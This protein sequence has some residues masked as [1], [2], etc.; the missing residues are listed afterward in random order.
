[1]D[2]QVSC[3]NELLRHFRWKKAACMDEM[4]R[5][6]KGNRFGQASIFLFRVMMGKTKSAGEI[7]SLLGEYESLARRQY[8]ALQ[9]SSYAQMSRREAAAYD[10]R[11]LRI[12]EISKGIVRL[13]SEGS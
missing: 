4:K 8:E 7:A 3:R 12:L 2:M 6:A 11:F 1:M 5:A 9:R 10:L 13:R